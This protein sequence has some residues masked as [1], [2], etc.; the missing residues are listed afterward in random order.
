MIPF[1]ILIKKPKPPRVNNLKNSKWRYK[2]IALTATPNC[3]SVAI[4]KKAS[5]KF[6]FDRRAGVTLAACRSNA[7][8]SNDFS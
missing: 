6:L 1:V 3:R 8:F 2:I 7:N 5:E 4:C